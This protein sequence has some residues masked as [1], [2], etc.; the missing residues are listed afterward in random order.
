MN[1]T[2]VDLKGKFPKISCNLHYTTSPGL[3]VFSDKKYLNEKEMKRL[4]HT[5]Y[6]TLKTSMQKAHELGVKKIECIGNDS[7]VMFQLNGETE[8]PADNNDNNDDKLLLYRYYEIKFWE[9]Q[10]QEVTF[11]YL[12]TFV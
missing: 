8:P 5:F 4:H 9:T 3:L 1:S 7:V 6:Q 10:F 11:R 12:R 2:V